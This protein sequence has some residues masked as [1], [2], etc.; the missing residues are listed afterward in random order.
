MIKEGDLTDEQK[1][2]VNVKL[3]FTDEHG[4]AVIIDDEVV[5]CLANLT[6]ANPNRFYEIDVYGLTEEIPGFVK[7]TKSEGGDHS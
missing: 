5:G 6:L 7:L 3:V 4:Y 2:R 1:K